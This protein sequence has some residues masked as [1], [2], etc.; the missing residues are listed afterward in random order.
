M[1]NYDRYRYE[2]APGEAPPFAF[3][4][5]VFASGRSPWHIRRLPPEE[6]LKRGGGIT[7]P[8]LCE[9]IQPFGIKPMSGGWDLNVRLHADHLQ[10]CC[11]KCAEL[12]QQVPEIERNP[13]T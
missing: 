12:Y 3:C 11:P 8:S 2:F 4:E 1:V 10:H 13:R 6:G 9:R 7:S 5:G